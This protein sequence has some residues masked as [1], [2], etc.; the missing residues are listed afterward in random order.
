MSCRN[1]PSFANRVYN[2]PRCLLPIHVTKLAANAHNP[3]PG[4]E[5][6]HCIATL[7]HNPSDR[8]IRIHDEDQVSHRQHIQMMRDQYPRP[9]CQRSVQD[10]MLQQM[11]TD[12]CIDR[13]ERIIQ[14]NNIRLGVGGT[15]DAN[16]LLLT[17]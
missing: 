13:T 14:E 6:T 7:L 4:H 16:A 1:S 12:C 2:Q 5:T 3:C 17:A 8:T 15:S 9:S 10:T 11:P